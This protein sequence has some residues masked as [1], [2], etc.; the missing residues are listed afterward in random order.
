MT[1]FDSHL[2]LFQTTA[3][4]IILALS[5]QVV[6]KTGLFSFASV[7]FFGIGGYLGSKLRIE[8]VPTVSTLLITIVVSAAIG[9]LLALPFAKLRGLYLGMVTVAFDQVMLIVANNGGS[10]TGGAI[11]LFGVPFGLSTGEMF[12]VAAIC[13]LLCSQLERGILGRSLEAIRTDENLAKSV[14]FAVLRDRNFI[15]SLSA[16]LGGLAG[17]L[18][19]M[20]FA[21][22]S[23]NA[24]TFE[25]VITGLTMA[26]VGG[27]GSWVGAVI[28]AVFVVW[29]PEVATFVDATWRA[30]IYGVLII[31]AVTYE[32]GGVFGLLRRGVRAVLAR[33]AASAERTSKRPGSVAEEPVA[34]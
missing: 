6:L 15:F 1:F 30:I 32:P 14:G 20:N 31:V 22:F 29:F 34:P 25:L 7:G 10:Y 21:S 26:V 19:A 18:S 12:I 16:A 8:G 4:Y 5:F 17:A 11:G 28:G 2:V 27:V 3:I 23:T 13:V 24:F 33:R 9:Y